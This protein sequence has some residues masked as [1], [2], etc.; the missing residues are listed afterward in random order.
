MQIHSFANGSSR[1]VSARPVFL[2]HRRAMPHVA[3]V[4]RATV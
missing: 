1:L 2:T 4:S 3:I